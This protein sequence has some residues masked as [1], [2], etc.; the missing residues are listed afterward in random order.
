MTC[1][2]SNYQISAKGATLAY[3][4]PLNAAQCFTNPNGMTQIY[5]GGW[6]SPYTDNYDERSAL[7]DERLAGHG[8]PARAGHV[9]EGRDARSPRPTRSG[10]SSRPTRGTTTAMRSRRRTPTSGCSTDAIASAN[11]RQGPV[12]RLVAALSLHPALA[13]EHVLRR[14]RHDELRAGS[15]IGQSEFGGLPLFKYNR[16]QFEYD[17]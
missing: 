7:Y 13:L 2:N 11:V 15:P 12:S 3:F 16:A 6:A 14:G 5:Y 8:R 4:L 17:F 10:S 1:N 9:V